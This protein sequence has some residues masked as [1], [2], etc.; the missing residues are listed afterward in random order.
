MWLTDAKEHKE[1]HSRK[2]RYLFPNGQINGI[3]IW[4]MEKKIGLSNQNSYFCFHVDELLPSC[5]QRHKTASQLNK[6]R[7][8][9]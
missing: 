4:N 6:E 5:R 8:V 3:R 1:T 7:L 2:S 9:D